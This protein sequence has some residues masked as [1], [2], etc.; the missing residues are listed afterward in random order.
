VTW[1]DAAAAVTAMGR[2]SAATL[3]YRVGGELRLT[4]VVKATFALVPD[5]PMAQLDADP[6]ARADA[7]RERGTLSAL[8]APT[9]LVPYRPR[10]D[11]LLLGHARAPG[12]RP[13][14]AMG[15]R[16]LLA[17][18]GEVVLDKRLAVRGSPDVSG[19]TREPSPFVAMELAWELAARTPDNPVGIRETPATWA[20]VVDPLHREL[21]A[22]FG[23]ITAAWP[24]RRSLL[25][26]DEADFAARI[27]ALPAD[28]AWGYF[29]AAPPDQRVPFLR[30]DEWV[31]YEG[32][33][34]QLARVQSCLPGVRAAARVYGAGPDADA[35]RAVTMEADGIVIDADRLCCSVV[36][37]GAV[38]LAREEDLAAVHVLAGTETTQR[39]LSFPPSFAARHARAPSVAPPKNPQIGA[40]PRAALNLGATMTLDVSAPRERRPATPF[41]VHPD[42][43]PRSAPPPTL[44]GLRMDAPRAAA[45]GDGQGSRPRS[46]P[47]SPSPGGRSLAQTLEIDASAL[48][49]ALQATP[50]EGTVTATPVPA[51]PD[52]LPAT[53]HAAPKGATVALDLASLQPPVAAVPFRPA[54]TLE[55]SLPRPP[56]LPA[57]TPFERSALVPAPIPDG[58]VTL[59]FARAA[60]MSAA[61]PLAPLTIGQQ[62]ARRSSPPAASPSRPPPM[63]PAPPPA[64]NAPRTLGAF[65]L[66]ALARREAVRDAALHDPPP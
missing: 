37:R 59:D 7:F 12:E 45:A 56:G 41:E 4:T 65:F 28:F 36:W 21:A 30:G 66:A 3:V 52:T 17:Q 16:L 31:G 62:A 47:P 19:R 1:G 14:P 35:G 5:G 44:D 50:F 6:I 58:P 23:P 32:L 57:A 13:T 46:A 38:T 40:S 53:P 60:A 2:S 33:S 43:R 55:P 11:V 9:D 22:G 18:G 24:M 42:G 51:P 8:L 63:T 25:T 54:P 34:A 10:A 48:Q 29:N 64:D 20:H 26:I 49:R 39:R 15:V 27:P 61:A